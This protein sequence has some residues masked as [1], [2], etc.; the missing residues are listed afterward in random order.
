ML[1]RRTSTAGWITA[2]SGITLAIVELFAFH[3][4]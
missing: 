1:Q 3:S 4:L 2:L